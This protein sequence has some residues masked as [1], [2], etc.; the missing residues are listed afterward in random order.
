M[1]ITTRQVTYLGL[2]IG[3]AI[4]LTRLASIRIAF[5]GV[6]GIRLGFGALPII[7]AGVYFG[8]LNGALV[9]ALADVVGYFINPMGAYMPHF[10]L[11]SALTGA[12]PG[13][14]VFWSG[15]EKQPSLGLLL[16]FIALGQLVTSIIL[17]PYFLWTLF[18][19]P[20]QAT[21]PPRIVAQF[22]Q[23]PTYAVF[24][25]I[26]LRR[27]RPVELGEVHKA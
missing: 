22:I 16:A 8:P 17:V 3:L 24:L 18:G 12:I 19:I 14:V 4:I 11:T 9:G 13:L 1:R 15:R 2:L 23:V 10:T 20:L 21:L 27:L 7:M 25:H 6:E 26:L 5:G